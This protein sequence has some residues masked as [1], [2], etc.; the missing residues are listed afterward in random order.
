MEYRGDIDGY[1]NKI[2][3]E[4]VWIFIVYLINDG[5]ISFIVKL[6]SKIC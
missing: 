1:D 5:D 3:C 6:T 2:E 4:S